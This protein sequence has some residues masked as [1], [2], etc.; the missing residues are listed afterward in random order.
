MC[1]CVYVRLCVR[2]SVSV[3]V[4]PYLRASARICVRPCIDVR[5]TERF[6]AS[7]SV[8][9]GQ[10]QCACIRVRKKSINEG[11]PSP[12]QALGAHDDERFSEGKFDLSA[13]GVTVIG[14]RGAVEDDP[15]GLMQLL[16]THV[17]RVRR[18]QF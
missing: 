1:V 4:C 5:L 6:S 18:G 11:A 13:Q 3:C 2:L 12:Q 16:Q 8:S 9:A 15:V 10:R 17:F 14:G 7:L